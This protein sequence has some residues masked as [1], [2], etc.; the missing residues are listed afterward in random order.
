M[1]KVEIGD[2]DASIVWTGPWTRAGISSEHDSTVSGS[3]DASST[4]LVTFTGTS[5]TVY[6]TIPKM[7]TNISSISQYTLDGGPL[8]GKFAPPPSPNIQFQQKFF[9]SPDLAYGLHQLHILD[10]ITSDGLW[11]D[12][13]VVTTGLDPKNLSYP[14]TQDSPQPSSESAMTSPG[15]HSDSWIIAVSVGIGGCAILAALVLT[16][17]S[18][19]RL[20]QSQR[21]VQISEPFPAQQPSQGGT[22]SVHA[23]RYGYSGMHRKL[24]SNL[25]QASFTPQSTYDPS[26]RS[27]GGSQNSDLAARPPVYTEHHFS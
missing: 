3:R 27:D 8:A 18:V 5:I 22:A 7:A 21:T 19:R 12:Y 23:S 26:A 1:S 16:V 24:G 17:Y 6:G 11:L 9:G 4:A 25:T 2:S 20:R 10:T 14:A 13:F 15:L